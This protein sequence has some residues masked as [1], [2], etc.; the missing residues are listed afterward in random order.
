MHYALYYWPGIQGRGEFVRLALEATEADYVDVARQ[1][2]RKGLGLPAM[3]RLLDDDA[4]ACP[5]F[6]PPFLKAGDQIIGHTANILLFLGARH[7]LAPREAAARLW[8]HQ[9]QLSVTDFVAEIH[10]TH[11]PI[12][13]NLYYEDQMPEAAARS[14]DFIENRLPKFLGYFSTVLARNPHE[15]GYLAG[16]RL[17]YVDLSMFQ[18]IEGLRYAFPN[19]MARIEPE[20]AGL[21][22]LHDRVAAHPPIARYLAS[23]RRIPFNQEGIFR[24]YAEL[25]R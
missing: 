14:A 6:A 9:L 4:L 21:I 8:V 2:A 1:S 16:R 3:M 7:R 17:S 5:P 20:H 13:G 11:H 12:A 19:A 24:H 23:A 10:D 22:E 15:S 25:D 18:L